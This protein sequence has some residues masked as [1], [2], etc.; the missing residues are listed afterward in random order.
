MSV[1]DSFGPFNHLFTITP[2]DTVDFAAPEIPDAIY[3]GGTGNIVVVMQDGTTKTLTGVL[4][5]TVY[6]LSGLRRINSTSTTAT[7]MLGLRRV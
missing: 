1:Q 5:G 2:S 7:A 4:A 6:P 3:V